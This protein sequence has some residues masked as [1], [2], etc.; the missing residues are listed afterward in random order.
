VTEGAQQRRKQK[1]FHGSG[2]LEPFV[3]GATKS[4]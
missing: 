4:A 2:G 3:V 1:S